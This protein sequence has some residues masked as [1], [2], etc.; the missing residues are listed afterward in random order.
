MKKSFLILLII[1][2]LGAFFRF[3]QLGEVPTSVNR[4]EAFLGYNAYSILKT[5]RDMHGIF[6]PL[7]L[8]SFLYSPAGYPYFSIPFIAIFDLN[9]FSIRFAS[10]LF[11]SLTILLIFYFTRKIFKSYKMPQINIIAYLSAFLLAISPW[12]IN[13]SRTAAEST[14]VVFFIISGA[15]LFIL[16]QEKEKLFLLL[17]SFFSFGVAIFTYQAPRAFLPFFIP[18]LFVTFLQYRKISKQNIILVIFLF[19]LT[20][21]LPVFLVLFSPDLSLRIKTVSIFTNAHTQLVIDEQLREDGVSGITPFLA[22][23]FHNKINGYVQAF[24]EN[25]FPHFSYSFLFTDTGYP[26]RYRVPLMG[27]LYFFE[28][29]LLLIGVWVALRVY[30]KIAIF[31]ILWILLAPTG[32][33]LASDDIPNLQRTLTILPPL[34]LFIALGTYSIFLF[35]K[36]KSGII[37][38]GFFA[39]L[40]IVPYSISYY[41]HQYYVHLD[42]YRPWYRHGGYKELVKEVNALLPRYKKAIITNHESAP[43]IFFLFYSKYDPLVFQKEINDGT[44]KNLDMISFGRYEFTEEPCPVR[45]NKDNFTTKEIIGEKDVLFVNSGTCKILPQGAT[46]IKS[47]NRTDNS[48]AFEIVTVN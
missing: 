24:I 13:L 48:K 25:Y 26:D 28:L 12:H 36:E 27:L 7:H 34:I 1:T 46:L 47:I 23:I 17:L 19:A 41:L 35:I 11:G 44:M 6:L 14:T 16:W 2:F 8:A 31:L 32:S 4:D 42:K 18:L 45:Y 10:A 5:S 21:L 39:L 38:I 20:I 15:I 37:R 3:Y 30:K 29:P 9:A 22:R 40:L 43:T 33:A